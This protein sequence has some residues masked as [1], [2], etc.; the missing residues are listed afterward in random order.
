VT[1]DGTY[2]PLAGVQGVDMTPISA[3]ITR[4]RLEILYQNEFLGRRGDLPAQA[5]HNSRLN[6]LTTLPY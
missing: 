2:P 3:V 6:H 4:S 1:G 5:K